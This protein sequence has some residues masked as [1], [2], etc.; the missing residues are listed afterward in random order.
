MI[1]KDVIILDIKQ[2][3]PEWFE[4]R[5]KY[6]TSTDTAI[7][8]R[9]NKH[10]G[11]NPMKLWRQ[12]IGLEEWD[13]ENEKMREG[14]ILEKEAREWYNEKHG[15]NFEPVCLMNKKYPW[16][17]TSLDGYDKA[18]GEV[19]EIKCGVFAYDKIFKGSMP[20]DYIDQAQHHICLSEQSRL[21]Y[22]AYRPDQTP[23]ELFI[24]RNE[25]L[26]N[27]LK[28][29]TKEFHE[30]LISQT[31]PPYEEREFIELNEPQT[32]EKAIKWSLAKI[33]AQKYIEEE[34]KAREELLDETD[35]GNCIITDANVK[36]LRI[37][38]QGNIDYKKLLQDFKITDEVLE[39]YRKAEISYLQPAIINIKEA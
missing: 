9:T 11:N 3:T 28:D 1:K 31:P 15:T 36:V 20:L 25:W 23:F 12:K 7:I 18:T 24:E 34:K 38:K 32:V 8:N 4:I 10:N 22:L 26:I 27:K 19:L 6:I 30:Y 14:R 16:M 33:N 13:E 29:K 39:K 37:V 17:F 35:D 5:K 2:G 21:H